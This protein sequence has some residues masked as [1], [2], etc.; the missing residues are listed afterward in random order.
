MPAATV[1]MNVRMPAEL[2]EQGDAALASE[3]ITPSAAVRAVWEKAARRGADLVELMSL[4]RGDGA[5]G[6]RSLTQKSNPFEEVSQQIT[7]RMQGLG[8]DF[9]Q[10][11]SQDLSDAELLEMAYYD[12]MGER[13]LL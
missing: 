2:K 8:V 11:H 9:S 12:K 1:Q 7:S 3:G 10:P 13:G 5:S 4:F 6:A